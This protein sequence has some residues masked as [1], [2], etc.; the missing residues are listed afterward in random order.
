MTAEI[1]Y[2]I[3]RYVTQ[4]ELHTCEEQCAYKTEDYFCSAFELNCAT[5]TPAYRK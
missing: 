1:K 3:N 5:C 4:C 2:F